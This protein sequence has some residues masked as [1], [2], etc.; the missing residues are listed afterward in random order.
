MLML[1][2]IDPAG[3]IICTSGMMMAGIVSARTVLQTNVFTAY[4]LY[5]YSVGTAVE[6]LRVC[7]FVPFILGAGL[8]LAI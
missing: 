6:L 8:H 7:F 2:L 4:L 1:L 5:T 3:A